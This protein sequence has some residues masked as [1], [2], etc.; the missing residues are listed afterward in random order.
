MHEIVVNGNRQLCVLKSM[1]IELVWEMI[2]REKESKNLIF[3]RH[4]LWDRENFK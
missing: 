2:C 1:Y 3:W 4:V